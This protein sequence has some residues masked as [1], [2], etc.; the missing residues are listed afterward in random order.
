[1]RK[2][3]VV[4]NIVKG[5]S[6]TY[7]FRRI[8]ESLKSGYHLE[9]VTLAESIISDRLLSFVKHHNH[10]VNVKT[11]FRDLIKFAKKLNNTTLLTK[12]GVDL[13]V[14]LDEWREKRNRC[15]HSVAKSEPDEPT[16]PVDVFL[17]MSEECAVKGKSLAR[18]TCEWHKKARQK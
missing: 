4:K 17:E 10:K 12:D 2:N 15:I 14:A 6:F 9:A 18:L 8:N 11:T 7:A 1:V 16:R 13:F 3:T 5:A